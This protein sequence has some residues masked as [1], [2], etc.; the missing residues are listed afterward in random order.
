MME[1]E[2]RMVVGVTASLASATEEGDVNDAEAVDGDT[3]EADDD[4]NVDSEDVDDV[5]SEEDPVEGSR[6]A[7]GGAALDTKD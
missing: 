5:E 1:A 7:P 2:R 3:A 6:M 4:D